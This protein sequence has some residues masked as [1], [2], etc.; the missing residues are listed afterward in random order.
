MKWKVSEISLKESNYVVTMIRHTHNIKGIWNS[1]IVPVIGSETYIEIDINDILTPFRAWNAVFIG[2]PAQE[3]SGHGERR[4]LKGTARTLCSQHLTFRAFSQD[5]PSSTGNPGP[6]RRILDNLKIDDARAD[7]PSSYVMDEANVIVG[8]I[9]SIDEDDLTHYLRISIDC[10]IMIESRKAKLNQNA[11]Y[12]I[13]VPVN[14]I[15][16]SVC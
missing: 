1:S 3:A 4:P 6:K 14:S 10:L 5:S 8:V 7:S 16:I 12:A 2:F 11:F 9:D 13:K 15:E